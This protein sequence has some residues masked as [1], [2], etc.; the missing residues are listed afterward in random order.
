MTRSA[1]QLDFRELLQKYMNCSLCVSERVN[2][3]RR[4]QLLALGVLCKLLQKI[5]ST[6]MVN[7]DE[8]SH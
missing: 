5:Q 3:D 6:D 7:C 1:K 8:I 4:S 2:V